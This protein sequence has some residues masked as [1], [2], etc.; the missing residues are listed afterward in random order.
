MRVVGYKPTSKKDV[1]SRRASALDRARPFFQ[2]HGAH[3]WDALFPVKSSLFPLNFE[4]Y[5]GWAL[6]T[7]SRFWWALPTLHYVYIFHK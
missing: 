4:I 6:P 1:R 3:P 2:S 7:L 5:V